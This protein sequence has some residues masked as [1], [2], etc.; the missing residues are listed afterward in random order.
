M[1]QLPTKL[2]E[3]PFTLSQAIAAG[4]SRYVL[5]KLISE[6]SVEQ[7]SRGIYRV[8]ASDLSE[9]EQYC[10][11]TLRVGTPSA[12]CLVSALSH[13]GLTDTIPRKT[14]IMV[15]HT[16]RTTYPELKLLRA[17]TPEW[18]IG[19]ER[20]N[21]YSITSLERTIVDCLIYRT[22]I[23]AQ[24]GIEALRQAVNSKKTTLGRVLDMAVRLGV[25]HRIRSYVEALS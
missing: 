12:I 14:W 13:Y 2:R 18:N 20:Q 23:G 3:K 6:G 15:E 11:A 24:I 21:G 10:A 22:K 17:R 5:S 16:K 8:T 1:G 7:L 25:D 9:E 19:I 4:V